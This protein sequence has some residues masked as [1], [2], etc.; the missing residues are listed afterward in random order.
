M[1]HVV[2]EVKN[3]KYGLNNKSDTMEEKNDLRTYPRIQREN[4][5]KRYMTV[6]LTAY[7]SLHLDTQRLLSVGAVLCSLQISSH[8]ILVNSLMI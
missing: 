2:I 1:K 6:S 7:S 4:D 3:S 5:S 8:L